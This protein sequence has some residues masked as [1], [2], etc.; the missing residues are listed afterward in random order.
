MSGSKKGNRIEEELSKSVK[1][2]KKV[3]IYGTNFEGVDDHEETEIRDDIQVKNEIS[4]LLDDIVD[5][6]V[7][8]ALHEF[9][10]ASDEFIDKK[11][12]FLKK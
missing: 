1:A 5:K 11:K 12:N 7:C 8:N 3:I 6:D 10:N 9:V 4:R 2:F